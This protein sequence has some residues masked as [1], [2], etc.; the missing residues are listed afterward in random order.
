MTGKPSKKEKEIQCRKKENNKSESLASFV[1]KITYCSNERMGG[2]D[3]WGV[4]G[5]GVAIDI[6][7]RSTAVREMVEM[8]TRKKRKN[9]RR[10]R[11][12]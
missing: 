10:G 12:M 3:Q 1:G 7:Y 5:N 11:S 8:Y 4:K 9:D 2:F 6:Y